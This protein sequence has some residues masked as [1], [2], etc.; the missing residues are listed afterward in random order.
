MRFT[1]GFLAIFLASSVAAQSV[2]GTLREA[3][4]RAGQAASSPSETLRRQ[5]RQR[6]E[7]Q[8]RQLDAANAPYLRETGGALR[9]RRLRLEPAQ[10]GLTDPGASNRRT[11][12]TG[13][14]TKILPLA[15]REVPLGLDVFDE[16]TSQ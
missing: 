9:Q 8:L 7:R 13:P 2:D 3:E 12:N 11:T 6:V 1:I 5:E 10:T 4:T 14:R 15:P 16:D